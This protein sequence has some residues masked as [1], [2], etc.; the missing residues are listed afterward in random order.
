MGF[1]FRGGGRWWGR[2]WGREG[3]GRGWS[4]V[5]LCLLVCFVLLSLNACGDDLGYWSVEGPGSSWRRGICSFEVWKVFA[6][7]NVA[8]ESVFVFVA[9]LQKWEMRDLWAERPSL[10][11]R[12]LH[13]SGNL[14]HKF[15]TQRSRIDT[16]NGTHSTQPS[17]HYNSTFSWIPFGSSFQWR[18]HGRL[19]IPAKTNRRHRSPSRKPQSIP[20]KSHG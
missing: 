13:C 7:R 14:S 1:L 16:S 3:V 11:C 18:S 15:R 17:R 6:N 8:I 5:V 19:A 2:G 9:C 4:V 12:S 10:R 20:S